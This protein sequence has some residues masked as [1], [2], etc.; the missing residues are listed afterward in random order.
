MVKNAKEHSM[1]SVKMHLQALNQLDYQ[2]KTGKIDQ[3]M[4]LELYFLR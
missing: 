4:G 1:E 2:I 3:N